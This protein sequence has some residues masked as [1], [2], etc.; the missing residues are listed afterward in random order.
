MERTLANATDAQL[1]EM[2]RL[3]DANTNPALT[4]S[5]RNLMATVAAELEAR[6][7]KVLESMDARFREYN[8]GGQVDKS[9][10]LSPEAT[11]EAHD[12]WLQESRPDGNIPMRARQALAWFHWA[13]YMAQPVGEDVNDLQAATV[14]FAPVFL[15]AP[16]EVPD[17]IRAYLV[18][19]SPAAVVDNHRNRGDKPASYVYQTY[20]KALDYA[21]ALSQ[22]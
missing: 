22:A 10:V 14:L 21:L 11:K 2:K 12:L 7:H 15:A 9:L 16:G 8:E 19:G 20:P 6:N 1:L 5:F 3:A 13:R 4:L 18:T 17:E